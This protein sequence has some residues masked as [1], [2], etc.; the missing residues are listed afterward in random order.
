MQVMA[1]DFRFRKFCSSSAV[2]VKKELNKEKFSSRTLEER[3]FIVVMTFRFLFE[4]GGKRRIFMLENFMH[5]VM[6]RAVKRE[7]EE[8]TKSERER[9]R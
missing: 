5:C 4:Q 7:R 9:E 1:G 3:H 2:S 6:H 8:E